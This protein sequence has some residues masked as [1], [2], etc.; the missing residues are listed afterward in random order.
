V[1]TLAVL[2][3]FVCISAAVAMLTYCSYSNKKETER[4]A[5]LRN[6][7]LYKQLYAEMKQLT[8][9]AVDQVRVESSGV[10]VTSLDPSHTLLQ[11]GFKGNGNCR[12]NAEIA[13]CIAQMLAQDFTILR[14]KETYALTRYRVYRLN[15]KREYGYVFTM[16]RA[17]KDRILE[18]QHS[19]QL[20][21]F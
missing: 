2:G 3:M 17:L 21:I 13:G 8:H 14:E 16:R 18:Y 19:P 10:V 9:L 4:M 20:R 11:Y 6:S 5:L 12:R 7:P 15:G 1:Q